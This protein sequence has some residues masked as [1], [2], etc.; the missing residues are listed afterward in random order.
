MVLRGRVGRPIVAAQFPAGP[1]CANVCTITPPER[2]VQFGGVNSVQPD[3][4]LGDDGVAVETLAGPMRQSG[5]TAEPQMAMRRPN[6]QLPYAARSVAERRLRWVTA[7]CAIPG[8]CL[9]AGWVCME[10]PSPKEVDMIEVRRT[11]ESDPWK[12]RWPSAKGRARP[13]TTSRSRGSPGDPRPSTAMRVASL[14]QSRH[15]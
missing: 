6:I 8:G 4:L 1:R 14:P 15:V 10:A 3:Q 2:L 13:V 9:Y 7:S 5:T 12:S 11:G